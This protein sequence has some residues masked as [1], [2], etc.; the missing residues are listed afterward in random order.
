MADEVKNLETKD[1]W[2]IIA[3]QV[4]G[5]KV[6]EIKQEKRDDG[7]VTVTYVFGPEAN[8]DYENWLMGSE[9]PPFGTTR[10]VH[11]YVMQFKKIL[12]RFHE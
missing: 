12:H 6:L 2:T 3:L 1:Y 10:L 7:R 9:D 5:H 8:E 11:K 4:C